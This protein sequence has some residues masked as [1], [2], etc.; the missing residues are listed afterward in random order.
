ML[1]GTVGSTTTDEYFS[2]EKLDL[3]SY[4]YSQNKAIFVKI[5]LCLQD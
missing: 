4:S 1:Y 5:E 3:F 2:M